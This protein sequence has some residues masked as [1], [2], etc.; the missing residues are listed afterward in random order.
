MIA[1]TL[2]GEIEWSP[3]GRTIACTRK[4]SIF[5]TDTGFQSFQRLTK[6][7]A[8]E[9]SLRWSADGK[10][11]LF[12]SDG[13]LMAMTMGQPGYSEIAKPA[14]KDVGLGLIDLSP[15][16]KSVVGKSVDLG[17]RRIIKKK[18]QT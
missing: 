7:E 18:T 1:D 12:A 13:K 8:G 11:L 14:G 9:N 16:R 2:L 6:S 3:D 10:M 4:G 15:D 5:L 17:G